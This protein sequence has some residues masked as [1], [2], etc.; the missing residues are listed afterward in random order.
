[1]ELPEEVW[2]RNR[3]SDP[4]VTRS[5]FISTRRKAH[6]AND[7]GVEGEDG[8]SQNSRNADLIFFYGAIKKSA[9]SQTKRGGAEGR[10]RTRIL[11]RKP[12]Q[13]E[14]HLPAAPPLGTSMSPS[15]HP[16]IELPL[17]TKVF[18]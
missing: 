9:R 10:D 7:K 15:S 8:D 17:R 5:Y 18:P 3:L 1:M 12:S 14:A 11:W 16:A 13:T 2:Q 4:A 6:G